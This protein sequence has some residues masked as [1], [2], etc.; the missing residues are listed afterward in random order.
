LVLPKSSAP[1][2]EPK[3]Q[4]CSGGCIL[5]VTVASILEQRWERVRIRK[6]EN[7]IVSK[8]GLAFLIAPLWVPAAIVPFAAQAFP[9]PEQ[10]HW[11]YISAIIAAIF[12]YAAVAAFG[13]PA[14]V[15]LRA[16]DFTALWIAP[17]LGFGVG[18]ITWVIFI[19][20]FGVSLGN[21]W[22]FVSHDL[23]S[24]SAHWWPLLPTG[25]L[26]AVVGATFWVI[27]RP[28]RS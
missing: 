26:G 21:G 1:G 15:I 10:G 2:Q 6:R 16:R 19:V 27:A 11:I 22:S 5:P 28:D 9:Y 13:M 8:T 24:N 17:V 23:A 3:L 25:T 7:A 14:F 4:T 20:L 12:A 18:I